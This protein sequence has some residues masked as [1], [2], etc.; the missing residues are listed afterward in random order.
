MILN[1]INNHMKILLLVFTK[2]VEE[3]TKGMKNN[4]YRLRVA[5]SNLHR[6]R[7]EK[8]MFLTCILMD[9]FEF[10]LLNFLGSFAIF[11]WRFPFL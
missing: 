10:L 8:V 11:M 9:P 4:N 6:C 1:E 2:Q 5:P 3:S 7:A